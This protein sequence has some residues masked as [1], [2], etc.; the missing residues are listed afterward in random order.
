M[1][2]GIRSFRA[3]TNL[4]K[5]EDGPNRIVPKRKPDFC[6]NGSKNSL[7]MS[8][9]VWAQPIG[10]LLPSF[11]P[12]HGV[13]GAIGC[14]WV[15]LGVIECDWVRMAHRRRVLFGC[16]LFILATCM[17]PCQAIDWVSGLVFC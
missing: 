4:I 7:N 17:A 8:E 15:L 14:D 6:S 1:L 11:V 10:F 2:S 3:L 12:H 9:P 5:Q 13:K 16:D